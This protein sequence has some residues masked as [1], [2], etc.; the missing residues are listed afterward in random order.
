MSIALWSSFSIVPVFSPISERNSRWHRTLSNG[1]LLSSAFGTNE[2]KSESS[3]FKSS[4]FME[5]GFG[6]FPSESGWVR[7]RARA[8]QLAAL[9]F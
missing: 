8:Q 9:L 2:S 7:A 4:T 5:V 1:S 3:L 6:I